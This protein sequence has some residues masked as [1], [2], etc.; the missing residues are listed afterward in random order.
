MVHDWEIY[1]V[2][3][4]VPPEVVQQ[5]TEEAQGMVTWMKTLNLSPREPL[6]TQ[7]STEANDRE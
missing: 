6:A 3:E 1:S 5:N 4:E 7:E 2:Q